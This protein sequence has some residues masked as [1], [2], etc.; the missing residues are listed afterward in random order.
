M[1]DIFDNPKILGSPKE[2]AGIMLFIVYLPFPTTFFLE[3]CWEMLRCMRM[4]SPEPDPEDV[5]SKS[6]FIVDGWL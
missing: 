2:Y 1:M 5:S 4:G 3:I 6:S